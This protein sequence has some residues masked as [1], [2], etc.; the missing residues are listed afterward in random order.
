MS[1]YDVVFAFIAERVRHNGSVRETELQQCIMNHFKTHS[2]VTDHPPVCAVGPHSGDPHYSPGAGS[3]APIKEGD[4][5]LIDLWAKLDRPRSVY[6]DLTWTCFVGREVPKKYADV[7]QIVA[8][9]RDAAI[10]RVQDA[11]RNH[12][13]LQ[14]WQVS[15]FAAGSSQELNHAFTDAD[16]RYSFTNLGEGTYDVCEAP[17]PGWTQTLPSPTEVFS[18][19]LARTGAGGY[20]IVIARGQENT[21]GVDF[22][23]R[24]PPPDVSGS[25]TGRVWNDFN[26]NGVVDA[27]EPGLAG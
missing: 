16:G 13:P 14:G 7:F 23:N 21:S 12:R 15:L 11:F 3:D 22:G 8:G 20:Q 19:C 25:K 10:A 5:V 2:L 9:A 27:G 18:N 6:S 17:A 24:L 1:A 26:G 4:F